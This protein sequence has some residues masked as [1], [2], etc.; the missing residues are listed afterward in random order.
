MKLL[1]AEA[2]AASTINAAHAVGLAHRVGSIEPGKLADLVILDSADYRMLGY[3]F[4]INQA[5]LVIKRGV[6]ACSASS[7]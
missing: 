4:G 6:P 1:P 2:L 5:A 7:T 3:R